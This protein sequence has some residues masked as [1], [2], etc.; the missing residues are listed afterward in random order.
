MCRSRVCL[1]LPRPTVAF[2]LLSHPRAAS[3][4]SLHLPLPLLVTHAGN[5]LQIAYTFT[6]NTRTPD[7]YNP[8]FS[9]KQYDKNK[10][11]GIPI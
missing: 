3:S 11:N 8:H 9:T 7:H 1:R 5:R 2:A 10:Q 4:L 6:Q